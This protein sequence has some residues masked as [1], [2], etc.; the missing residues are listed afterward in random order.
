MIENCNIR[1][2]SIFLREPENLLFSSFEYHGSDF[3]KDMAYLLALAAVFVA[4]VVALAIS[5]IF[6][7]L[8]Y[9]AAGILLS[10]G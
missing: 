7:P 9:I 5:P 1:N 6:V 8:G 4:G 10:S 2:C 3:V